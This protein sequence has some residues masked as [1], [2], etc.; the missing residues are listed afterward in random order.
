MV[1]AGA[2][3]EAAIPVLAL[4][5][6]ST[7]KS[8]RYSDGYRST[9]VLRGRPSMQLLVQNEL[10]LARDLETVERTEMLDP[11]LAAALE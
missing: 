3:S 6:G 8:T 2:A 5:S 10:A 9:Q 4:A 11:D 1:A 7:A